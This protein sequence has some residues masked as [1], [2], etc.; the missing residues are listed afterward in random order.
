MRNAI[1][2]LDLR[3][4]ENPRGRGSREVLRRVHTALPGFGGAGTIY[5]RES[6]AVD[7]DGNDGAIAQWQ[8]DDHGRTVCGNSRTTRWLFHGRGERP[9]RG[10]Q[11]RGEDTGRAVGHGGSAAGRRTYRITQIERNG[12]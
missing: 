7:R 3:R 5:F 12:T 9:Q 8:T 6:L 1:H 11:D 4:G 10:D 2:A